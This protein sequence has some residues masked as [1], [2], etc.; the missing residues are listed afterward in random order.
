MG[1]ETSSAQGG[2]ALVCGGMTAAEGIID[3]HFEHSSRL[4]CV[5]DRILASAGWRVEEIEAVGVGLGP[6]SFTGIRVGLATAKGLAYALKIPI[7]GVGSLLALAKASR[8]D[9][10]GIATVARAR[11]GWYYYA[12]FRGKGEE[13]EEAVSPRLI[14][15][16][17]L[18]EIPAR[19]WIVS[20]KWEEIRRELRAQGRRSPRGENL[21]PS[22]SAVARRAE[23]KASASLPSE[24]DRIE[25]VYLSDWPAPR[26]PKPRIAQNRLK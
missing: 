12:L 9:G 15:E 19:A 17:E 7:Y 4:I 2:L 5:L 8:R 22:P 25:P 21:F 1:I 14:E 11:R 3:T 26:P 24:A 18:V 10:A 13:L 20:P 6:G 16:R 23:A